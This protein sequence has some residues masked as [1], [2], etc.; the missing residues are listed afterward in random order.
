MTEFIKTN[1]LL[2]LNQITSLYVECFSKGESAQYIDIDELNRYVRFIFEKG[3]V[4]LFESDAVVQAALL[5]FSLNFVEDLPFDIQ[6]GFKLENCAYVAELMVTSTL[7]GQGVAKALI[8]YFFENLDVKR[9]QDVIIRV[10]DKNVTALKLYEKM[11][12]VAIAQNKQT[13]TNANGIGDFEMQKIY[14]HKK[15]A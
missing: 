13:K 5:S 7:R 12:F 3:E 6:N 14:L 1:D 9:Y 2:Y 4:I 10:W 8:R 15:I 11:G